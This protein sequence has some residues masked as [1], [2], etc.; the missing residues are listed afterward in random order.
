MVRMVRGDSWERLSSFDNKLLKAFQAALLSFNIATL[1]EYALDNSPIVRSHVPYNPATTIDVIRV[2]SEDTNDRVRQSVLNYIFKY[3]STQ[4][5][6]L[7]DKLQ[8]IAMAIKFIKGSRDPGV[9]RRSKV[10]LKRL[11]RS[12]EPEVRIDLLPNLPFEILVDIVRTVEL[13]RRELDILIS[14]SLKDKRSIL[15]GENIILGKNLFNLS[16]RSLWKFYRSPLVNGRLRSLVAAS[17]VTFLYH[18]GIDAEIT[19]NLHYEADK[20]LLKLLAREPEI[21]RQ[22]PYDLIER[23]ADAE[24]ENSIWLKLKYR[25][26]LKEE[27]REP[28]VGSQEKPQG[29][30]LRENSVGALI[31]KAKI[32]L[33]T[34]LSKV[35]LRE[36]R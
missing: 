23:I 5:P 18:H 22:L 6:S 21:L 19:Y 31:N 33:K 32:L 25:Y 27:L 4:I 36:E 26:K 20:L 16:W 24:E 10:L 12:L 2:L 14:L 15:I 29:G 17:I 30:D 7:D 8:I 34:L 35:L 28:L 3:I 11:I 13:T 1:L 9:I